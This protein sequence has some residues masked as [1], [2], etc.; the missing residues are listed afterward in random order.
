METL[1]KNLAT[2]S[3]SAKSSQSAPQ[4]MRSPPTCYRCG[5]VAH[6]SKQCKNEMDDKKTPSSDSKASFK[7]Y[8]Y[9]GY[10]HIAKN[11]ADNKNRNN[12]KNNE[13][14]PAEKV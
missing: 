13:K 6:L 8:K 5:V 11:C 7:C 2:V 10:G 12:E 9:G 3:A 14:L 1:A 4:Q